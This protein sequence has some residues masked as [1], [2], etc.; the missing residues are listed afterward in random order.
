MVL[1]KAFRDWC[2]QHLSNSNSRLATSIRTALTS[3]KPEVI[4]SKK[5]RPKMSVHVR[6]RK[7][8]DKVIDLLATKL[9]VELAL[10]IIEQAEYFPYTIIGS[11]IEE[12]TVYSGYSGGASKTY[13][14][15]RIPFLD[16]PNSGEDA[17][18]DQ[19]EP[20][21]RVVQKIVFRTTSHDQGWGGEPGCQGSYR[22]AFSWIS[23]DI[24]RKKT[25]NY[26]DDMKTA[27]ASQAKIVEANGGDVN[28][29]GTYHHWGLHHGY[30]KIGTEDD[31]D[32]VETEYGFYGFGDDQEE[33]EQDDEGTQW[34]PT[35]R[36]TQEAKSDYY[37]VG[38]WVLQ[39]NVCAKGESTDHE[40]V[41]DATVDGPGPDV[42]RWG[43][44]YKDQNGRQMD[45][46]WSENGRVANS[47]FVKELREGDEIRVMM[48]AYFGGWSCTVEKCEVE[49]W[50]AV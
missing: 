45:T 3:P 10:D 33:E 50:W 2:I 46:G 22:G 23:V 20:R 39:R 28:D 32:E 40:I 15:V 5:R 27:L 1:P 30:T 34:G 43:W 4:A 9:P 31:K 47:T 49:C 36:V 16:S 12:S 35:V 17:Q 24:W 48:R 13:L 6:S 8:V 25:D 41:W 26:R 19:Q 44:D 14:V 21:K 11:G 37:K 29:E 42:E 38:S 18:Q 7:E